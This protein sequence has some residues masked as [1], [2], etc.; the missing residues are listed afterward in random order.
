MNAKQQKAVNKKSIY[1]GR[2]KK[3]LFGSALLLLMTIIHWISAPFTTDAYLFY[4]VIYVIMATEDLYIYWKMK[5][6]QAWIDKSMTDTEKRAG[7]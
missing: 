1:A 7:R 4:G 5:A 6:E 2:L 3:D